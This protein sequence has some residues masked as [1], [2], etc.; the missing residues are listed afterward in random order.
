VSAERDELL[1]LVRQIPDEQVPLALADVRRHLRPVRSPW[2]PA[3]F[4]IAEG[5][6]TDVAARSEDLLQ[7]GFGR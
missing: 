5:D 3:W 1:R 4:G 6:G 7:E 2:P